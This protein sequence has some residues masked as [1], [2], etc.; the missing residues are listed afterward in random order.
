MNKARNAL[1]IREIDIAIER[2]SA[3]F[4]K[5]DLECIYSK[6]RWERLAI[7][8]RNAKNERTKKVSSHERDFCRFYREE[9]RRSRI[10]HNMWR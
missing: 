5:K 4:L 10:D 6:Y 9:E 1:F 8:S 2:T 3:K 7:N